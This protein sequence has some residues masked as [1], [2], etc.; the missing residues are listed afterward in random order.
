MDTPNI[1]GTNPDTG[2]EED[3]KPDD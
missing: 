1:I 2:L 3:R